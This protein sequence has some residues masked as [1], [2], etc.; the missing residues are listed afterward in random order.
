MQSIHAQLYCTHTH[1]YRDDIR[2]D[3]ELLEAHSILA[4]SI[5]YM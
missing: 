5:M 3:E 2:A 1:T 4:Y